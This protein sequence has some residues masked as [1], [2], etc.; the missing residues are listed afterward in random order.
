M[1]ETTR[2]GFLGLLAALPV[3]GP[4]LLARANVADTSVTFGPHA[5]LAAIPWTQ[6]NIVSRLDKQGRLITTKTCYGKIADI[7]KWQSIMQ[8]HPGMMRLATQKVVSPFNG[9]CSI[10]V[11]DREIVAPS[12]SKKPC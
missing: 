10:C 8:L 12:W 11:E 3:I 4:A 5:T 1:S 2:R 6:V 7:G 9:Y